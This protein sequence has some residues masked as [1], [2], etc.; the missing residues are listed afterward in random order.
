MCEKVSGEMF[1]IDKPIIAWKVVGVVLGEGPYFRTIFSPSTGWSQPVTP[2]A[3]THI[4]NIR[5][6]EK[7]CRGYHVFE[8]KAGAEDYLWYLLRSFH[9]AS[10]FLRVQKVLVVGEAIPFTR[11]YFRG[12]AV[13]SWKPMVK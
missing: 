1:R 4:P 5:G 7:T 12:L 2:R 10:Y 8:T 9:S 13:Q 3:C 6:C 11:D